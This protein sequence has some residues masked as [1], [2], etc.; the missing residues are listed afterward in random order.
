MQEIVIVDDSQIYLKMARKLLEESYNVVAF[1][2]G[3]LALRYIKDN[4]PDLLLLDINMP[5]MDGRDLLK[6]I[7]ADKRIADIPAIFLT[8]EESVSIESECFKI[9]A[10]DF[11]CKPFVPVV[12]KRRI[13]R[14]IELYKLRK[15]L[16]KE[17]AS[18]QEELDVLIHNQMMADVDPLTGLYNRRHCEEQIN[19]LVAFGR[20]GALFMIDLDNFKLV[21][22]T[23]GHIEGDHV[24]KL[25][26]K[27]LKNLAIDDEI[28]CRI[29]G[30]EF[31]LFYPDVKSRRKISK[32]AAGIIDTFTSAIAG[33]PYETML[34]VSIGISICPGDGTN[35][36][37]LY[38][39]ADKALYCVKKRGKNN[40]QFFSDQSIRKSDTDTNCDIEDIRYIIEG[41]LNV[42]RGAYSLDYEDFK[43][44][45][46]YIARTVNRYKNN[47][48]TVLFTLGSN[49]SRNLEVTELENAMNCLDSSVIA[50]LRTVDVGTKFSNSQ[51]LVILVDTDEKNADMVASRV[52]KE[53]YDSS[54]EED[55][56]V[57][58]EIQ[59]MQPKACAVVAS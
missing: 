3:K 23:Y 15:C 38:A 31:I 35:F 8:S 5:G 11:I 36:E 30:D 56:K 48:Q 45:Y 51:Y 37:Q 16:E 29:G 43:N 57:S 9:G 24:L 1:Q 53:F 2:D 6:L 21:N 46:A 59:T 55:V 41:R 26:A 52:V 39:N 12:M 40:Y 49:C 54:K 19:Q 34:S 25:F 10:D 28:I 20:E 4:R 14:T 22:D 13:E 42:N 58:Y 18:K 7:R 47:V 50:A 44:V 27:T 32:F 17:L 33:T